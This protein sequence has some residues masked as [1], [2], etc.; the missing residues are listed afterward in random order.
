VGCVSRREVNQC[1]SGWVNLCLG[2]VNIQVW[3][4][5]FRRCSE[6]EKRFTVESKSFAFAVL[7]GA[8]VLRVVEKRNKVLGEVVLST[9]CANWL[10]ST[11]EVLLG[12]PEEQEFVKSFREGSKVLIARRGGNRAG[13]F[14]E[15]TIFGLGG[16]KGF[17][18]IPEGRGG[19]GWQKF[20]SELSKAVNF[21]FVTM[22]SGL[23]SSSSSTKKDAKV[24]GPSLGLASK[25]TGLSFAEVLCSI[26]TT[27]VKK[28]PF[29]G[30][31]RSGLK[32]SSEEAGALVPLPAPTHA[33]QV[34]SSAVGCI[35][36]ESHP[37]DPLVKD[38][39]LDSLGKKSP[40]RSNL[41]FKCSIMRMWS[42]L[43]NDLKVVL[44]RAIRKFLGRLVGSG[45]G[46]KRYGF[47]LARLLPKPKAHLSTKPGVS[48]SLAPSRPEPSSSTVPGALPVASSS[49][50]SLWF[51]LLQ[52]VWRLFRQGRV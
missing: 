45:L 41:N 21:L 13:R 39:S 37:P 18:I 23:G 30:G 3:T 10:V 9:Q 14:L 27:A 50:S 1:Y 33:E 32:A 16:R 31:L 8:S 4:S 47:R 34:L 2:D 22:G 11:L 28:L 49:S 35:D 12:I 36:L 48:P 5:V 6:M 29:M 51:I 44:G 24:L 52:G 42:K 46:R 43:V 15:T 40:P 26:P 17:I 7:D 19:W 38:R 20:S 25:W